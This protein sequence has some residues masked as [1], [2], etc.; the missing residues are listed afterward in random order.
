M[1]NPAVH[2]N[3]LAMGFFPVLFV[4]LLSLVAI[5]GLENSDAV[6]SAALMTNVSI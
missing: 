2:P 6:H 5:T 1:S 4:G 3:I